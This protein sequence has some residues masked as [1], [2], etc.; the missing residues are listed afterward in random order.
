M[1]E[2]VETK[3]HNVQWARNLFLFK[4]SSH[5]KDKNWPKLH[6]RIVCGRNLS[7]VILQKWLRVSSFCWPHKFFQNQRTLLSNIFFYFWS[8]A[9]KLENKTYVLS[10]FFLMWNK[11]AIL[12]SLDLTCILI[13][14]SILLKEFNFSPLHGFNL[15]WIMDIFRD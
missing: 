7:D 6:K 11:W 15:W 1:K 14:L 3:I 8:L 5:S 13:M 12:R 2:K 10:K 9:A 4:V